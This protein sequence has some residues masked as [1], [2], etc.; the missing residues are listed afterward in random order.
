MDVKLQG[1]AQRSDR[2]VFIQ[3]TQGHQP[4]SFPATTY[5]LQVT[6]SLSLQQPVR[7]VSIVEGEWYLSSFV[8]YGGAVEFTNYNVPYYFGLRIPDTLT[9]V[10]EISQAVFD[11]GAAMQTTAPVVLRPPSASAVQTLTALEVA[12]LRQLLAPRNDYPP[13]EYDNLDMPPLEGEEEEEQGAIGY[14]PLE[15]AKQQKARPTAA[16]GVMSDETPLLEDTEEEDDEDYES[17]LDDDDYAEMPSLLKYLLTPE[18]KSLCDDLKRKGLD[19]DTA[20]KAAQVAFPH[21][22][23]NLWEATYHNGLVDGLSPPSA[24]DLAWGAISEYI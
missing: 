3:P 18:A 1:T 22:A 9:S 17:D 7:T 23:R 5:T 20:V 15:G 24:R 14:T 19:H 4:T 10:Y 11:V 6:D 12:Q 13:S 2:F 8:N 16:V 21:P